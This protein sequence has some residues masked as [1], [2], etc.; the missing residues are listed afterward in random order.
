MET[1]PYITVTGTVNQFNAEDCSFVMT[2]KQ[3]VVLTHS[4]SAL[5]VYTHFADWH[6]NKRWGT[7]EPKVTVGTTITFSSFFQGNILWTEPLNLLRL[8]L[9]ALP[10]L[11][12]A[13]ILLLI[14][15]LVFLF[16]K[17]CQHKLMYL[18]AASGSQKW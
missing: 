3:Y 4:Y 1:N 12:L 8:K 10:T 6:S 11:V 9:Q 17:S 18:S 16:P 2:P 7:D 14:A 5:P 13:A 15:P